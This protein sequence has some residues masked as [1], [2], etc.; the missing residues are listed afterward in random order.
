ML[1]AKGLETGLLRREDA[2][3]LSPGGPL[4]VQVV[5]TWRGHVACAHQ[6]L[7]GAGV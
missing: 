6:V 4:D 2:V 7:F 5:L 3:L 1:R